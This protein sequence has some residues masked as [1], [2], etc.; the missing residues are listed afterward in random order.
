MDKQVFISYNRKDKKKVRTIYDVLNLA[1]SKGGAWHAWLDAEELPPGQ[2]WKNLAS[3]ALKQSNARR[4]VTSPGFEATPGGAR[5]GDEPGVDIR[6][7]Y[8]Y[9]S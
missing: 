8:S 3:E 9:L 6:P 5:Y 7:Q 4:L 2:P 1:F